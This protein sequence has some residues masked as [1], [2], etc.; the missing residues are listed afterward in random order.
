MYTYSFLGVMVVALVSLAVLQYHW[1]GSVSDAEK[2]RLEENLSAASE[3]FVADFNEVFAELGQTF[4]VQVSDPNED[5][6]P[7]LNK[8][9]LTW[10]G[11][12]SYPELLDSVFVVKTSDTEP[13]EVFLFSSD[14]A[15]LNPISPPN[16]IKNWIDRNNGSAAS[17]RVS[18]RIHPE[19]GDPSF[20]SVPVQFL[21]M[22]QVSNREFGQKVEVQL[23]VDQ[24]DDVVLL[25]L[26]DD[27]IKENVI[28]DIARTYFSDSYDDQYTLSLIKDE[29]ASTVYFTSGDSDE[30]PAPDFT[31][32][33]DK[34]SV[35]NILV[36]QTEPNFA[37][38]V[39]FPNISESLKTGL[40]KLNFIE[41]SAFDTVQRDGHEIQ[42]HFLSKSI[43]SVKTRDSN[44]WSVQSRDTTITSNLQGSMASSPWQL[45]LSFRE[46]SL[47]EFVNKTRNRNLGISFGILFILGI[48]VVLI[49]VFSQRSRD[50]AEQQMLF[51]AGVSHELRTPITVIRSA[52]ENLTEGV[53]QSEER[54]KEYASLMLK[55]GRRLSDMVDQIMEFSGIQ[56]GKRIYHFTQVN[57]DELF[58]SIKE[59]SRHLLEEK[60]M[61]LEYSVNTSQQSI[62]AD[63]DA[64]FLCISNLMSNAIKF[65]GTSK[66][67]FMKVNDEFLKG[68]KALRIQVQ[69]F[70]IGI[71]EKEQSEIFK[72]FFRGEKPVNDQVKGNGIGLSLVQKV[73][74]AH[75]GE[76]TLKSKEGEGSLF[77]I[78][79]PVEGLDVG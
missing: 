76:I 66:K 3:N 64:L 56:T 78:I 7:A 24:L 57:L 34:F 71:P 23:S 42:S 43:S 58:T 36:F 1:L 50:L 12:S 13:T 74:E 8:A 18:L 67:I 63:P 32:S 10:I 65:S 52:A 44:S 21:D 22:I 20:M 27:V 51:V 14:P 29:G 45:W 26:D 39:R 62:Y 53:V 2:E 77:S 5:L 79:L 72:P 37:E 30:I 41:E 55:E 68:S 38:G 61:H 28:P 16:S 69:D 40:R 33:L 47:D 48:S 73:V 9:L 19:L 75:K 31:S 35:S 60:E 17:K 6:K 49:V 70:G 15:L 54:K 4:R 46:G 59:E 25:K 11:N